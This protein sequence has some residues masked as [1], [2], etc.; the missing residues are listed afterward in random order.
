MPTEHTENTEASSPLVF[1]SVYSVC[2]VG[3]KTKFNDQPFAYHQ[4]IE[5]EI[6]TLTNL[7]SGLGRVQLDQP[8]PAPP[9]A[10]APPATGW[11]VMVKRPLQPNDGLPYRPGLRI[12][13]AAALCRGPAGEGSPHGLRPHSAR[14]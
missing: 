7:G 13:A 11:V 2:S 9:T 8:P 3:K 14:S 12:D 1:I 10:D 6:I 5:L 4:V